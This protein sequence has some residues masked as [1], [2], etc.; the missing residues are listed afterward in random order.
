NRVRTE[1]TSRTQNAFEYRAD[2]PGLSVFAVV[3]ENPDDG[4]AAGAEV[5]PDEGPGEDTGSP[6]GEPAGLS[7]IGLAIGVGLAVILVIALLA[8]RARAGGR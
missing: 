4:D 5:T 8:S 1:L 2:S 7:G 6:I 3:L